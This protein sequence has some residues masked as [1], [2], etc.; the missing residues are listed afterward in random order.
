MK[1][2]I[3]GE[4]VHG[5]TNTRYV[6]VVDGEKRPLTA[7][8]FYGL[9]R[10]AMACIVT[11]GKGGLYERQL[12]AGRA[13]PFVNEI[14]KQSGLPIRIRQHLV[15]LQMAPRD[16]EFDEAVIDNFPNAQIRQIVLAVK[17]ERMV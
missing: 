12:T 13:A 10:L 14:K 15:A 1:I 16:I 2:K 6:V 11:E 7:A 3:T 9:S 8:M 17:G 4:P 5:K